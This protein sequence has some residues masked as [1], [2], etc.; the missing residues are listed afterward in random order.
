M[1][2]IVYNDKTSKTTIFY[3]KGKRNGNFNEIKLNFERKNFVMI[4][5]RWH[6]LVLVRYRMRNTKPKKNYTETVSKIERNRELDMENVHWL[7]HDERTLAS[8]NSQACM[9]HILNLDQRCCVTL[10][11]ILD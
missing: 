10:M 9:L 7:S 11:R 3:T 4:T 5:I 8:L 1:K 2:H 6:G